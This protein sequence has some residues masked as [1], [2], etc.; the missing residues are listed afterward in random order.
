MSVEA[1]SPL[2]RSVK[3]HD[4]ISAIDS[5]AIQSAE[6]AV[7][8]LN[9]RSEHVPLIMSLDRPTKGAMEHYTVRVPR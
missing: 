1:E 4:V 8:I 7:R 9:Q 5:Q 6:Q 3:A 2:A